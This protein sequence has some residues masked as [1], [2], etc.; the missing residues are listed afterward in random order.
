MIPVTAETEPRHALHG[1][2]ETG[3]EIFRFAGGR[4]GERVNGGTFGNQH[5]LELKLLD[6]LAGHSCDGQAQAHDF[7]HCRTCQIRIVH[8]AKRTDKDAQ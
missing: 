6:S 4:A 1:N 5:T 8:P 2:I 7:L 3:C